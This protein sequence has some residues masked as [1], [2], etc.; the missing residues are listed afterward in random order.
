MSGN[1]LDPAETARYARQIR[2][3]G[4]GP[5][6][7]SALL[8]SHV[9]VI[10]AGGLGA[11]V[12][13]YLAA[14][15]LGRISIV[16]PDT[17]ELSN[18]HR[19]FIHS[20]ARVGH[21]KVDSAKERMSELNS[22]LDIIT[23]PVLLTPDNALELIGPAD[24]VI[25]GSDNF[26][27]RYLANDACE[28]LE[29]PLV[30]GTILGFD[31]Q[32]AVFDTTQGVTLR[33]LYPVVPAPGSVPDCATAGVL[34][35]LCGSIGAAMAMETIKVLTGIGTP[36]YNSVAIH[37]SLDT[38]WETIPVGRIPQREPIAD[39]DRHLGD[40]GDG[41]VDESA[42]QTDPTLTWA[43]VAPGTR[44]VDIREM[45][46]VAGGMVPGAHHVP[47]DEL[48]ADPGRIAD[49]DAVALYCRSGM[50]SA[51]ACVALRAQGIKVSSISG[52]Y[53]AYLSQP[54]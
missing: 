16:D 8:G 36:L 40:Y 29:K 42:A 24:I 6:A 7:Q 20:E 32:V 28:I 23:H 48:L 9:I 15:G 2:L 53:L 51:R 38:S 44:L 11:P 45:D 25:D 37:S 34:G 52:G 17:V 49:H 14:A 18:L 41:V 47:M 50:R 54:H 22:S 21:R 27:T 35:A 30:W 39:L 10:G 5:Q 13:T 19:Q 31:G 26:A 4:F 46:E 12:L 33:D 43:T 1:A 3:T